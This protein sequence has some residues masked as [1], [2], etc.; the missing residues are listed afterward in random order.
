M[1]AGNVKVEDGSRRDKEI[2]AE[3]SRMMEDGKPPAW[4]TKFAAKKKINVVEGSL[5][6]GIDEREQVCFVAAPGR[7]EALPGAH[8]LALHQTAHCPSSLYAGFGRT[9]A[10]SGEC[11]QQHLGRKGSRR[12]R[13]RQ[14]RRRW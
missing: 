6:R 11:R 2:Q 12:R 10:S 3:K 14:R 8:R 5:E 9:T 7:D 1:F 4:F 13:Q